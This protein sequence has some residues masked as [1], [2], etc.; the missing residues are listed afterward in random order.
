MRTLLVGIF[1][2]TFL[3]GVG[4]SG[5][6]AEPPASGVWWYYPV[7]HGT[8]DE[9]LP[10]NAELLKVVPPLRKVPAFSKADKELGLAMWWGDYSQL[11]YSEQPPSQADLG[12]KPVI[13][14][15][16]GEDEPLVLGLWGIT[17]SGAVTLGVTKSPFPVTIRQIVFDPRQLPTPYREVNVP[18]GRVVGFSTYMPESGTGTVKPGENTVFWINVEVPKGTKPGNYQ[19][20]LNLTVHQVKEMPITATVKV[21]P[22]DLPTADIAYGMYFRGA[23]SKD[24]S[25]R[26]NTPEL[27]RAYWQ[28]MARH[29]MTSVS[30][31]QY[32]SSGDF[33]DADGNLKSLDT[34]QAVAQLQQM[35]EIGLIHPNI[36]IMLL[37][38]NLASFPEAAKVVA[39]EFKKRGLPELL[40]Y[41]RDE[42][43]VDDA[44]KAQFEAMKPVRKYMRTTTAITDYAAAAYADLIDVWTLNGGRVTPEIQKLASEKGKELWTYDCTHRGRGNSAR[45]RFY[46]G[47]YTWALKLRGNFYWC[48]TE[49]YTWEGDRNSTFCFVL[50]S[51][52]GPVPSP[53]WEARREGIED[54]RTLHFLESR[55]AANPS[56]SMA[57]EASQWLMKLRSRVDWN[58]I[59]YMPKSVYP[60][61]GAE[62][63]PMCPGFDPAEFPG[64]R[65]KAQEFIVKLGE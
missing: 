41:G 1:V 13:V 17:R 57:K 56:S 4:A 48:Y 24:T 38:S 16:P 64:I 25:E 33:I 63:F 62:V 46:S 8:L 18:G 35:K 59:K 6:G 27:T 36:P 60:W 53:A 32:T 23:G 61:D 55:I 30:Y 47:L 28:D 31:Y 45:A 9:P 40:L 2:A 39:E 42:P 14:T 29:G 11:I 37:S 49:G 12:R 10:S 20:T 44:T 52:S 26:Y 19:I 15:P 58:L 34:H 54:Y 50:P 22:F 51:D 5:V 21:L 3:A 7:A 43:P 65:A